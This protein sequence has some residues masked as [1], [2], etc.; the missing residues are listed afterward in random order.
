MPIDLEAHKKRNCNARLYQLDA[1]TSYSEG[2]YFG[3]RGYGRS[4][5]KPLYASG[6]GLSYT[7]FNY[8]GFKLHPGFVD[9]QASMDAGFDVSNSGDVGGAAVAEVYVSKSGATSIARRRN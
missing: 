7:T 4:E 6:H 8:S 1:S 9:G 2:L 5:T 3:Y